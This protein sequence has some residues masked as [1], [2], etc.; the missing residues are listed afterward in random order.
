MRPFTRKHQMTKRKKTVAET[1]AAF[2]T[3]FDK[4]EHQD[5]LLASAIELRAI[6]LGHAA[7]G[8]TT[9]AALEAKAKAEFSAALQALIFPPSEQRFFCIW[10]HHPEA[11]YLAACIDEVWGSQPGKY[12]NLPP[13]HWHAKK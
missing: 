9:K 1:T 3:A 11:A 10:A 8:P 2:A 13:Q 12:G 5:A 6:A 7:D 4:H